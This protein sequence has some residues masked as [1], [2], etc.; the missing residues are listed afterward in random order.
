MLRLKTLPDGFFSRVL[1]IFSWINLCVH[2]ANVVSHGDWS[3][4]QKFL[5]DSGVLLTL[6][7]LPQVML[8]QRNPL[9][10]LGVWPFS[11]GSFHFAAISC[12]QS[13][14]GWK[15]LRCMTG[16]WWLRNLPHPT[17]PLTKVLIP[18]QRV[19]GGRIFHQASVYSQTIKQ[20]AYQSAGFWRISA[21]GG[22]GHIHL[23]FSEPRLTSYSNR[24]TML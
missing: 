20:I 3:I 18:L 16:S 11:S 4:G 6:W 17:P 22:A 13:A 8:N 24:I 23:S 10:S 2:C 21:W 5:G 12:F 14:S 1:K 7:L 9:F 15:T 19:F